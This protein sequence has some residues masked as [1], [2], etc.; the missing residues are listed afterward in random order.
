M[1]ARAA[2]L[3]RIVIVLCPVVALARADPGVIRSV[4]LD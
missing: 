3:G 1:R 4:D 2:D